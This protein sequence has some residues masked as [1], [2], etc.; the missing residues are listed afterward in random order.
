MPMI[1]RRKTL[2]L[3]QLI[4]FLSLYPLFARINNYT[5]AFSSLSLLLQVCSPPP[6]ISNIAIAK[7]RDKKRLLNA[8]PIS[9]G[10]LDNGKN[11]AAD[12]GRAQ[13]S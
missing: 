12:Y 10:P 4:I 2:L 13:Y 8:D 6:V 3:Y 9:K 11:S 1:E 5:V 7:N